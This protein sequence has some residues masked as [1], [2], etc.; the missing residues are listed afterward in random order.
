MGPLHIHVFAAAWVLDR[1]VAPGLKRAP[2]RMPESVSARVAL[3][4]EFCP[5]IEAGSSSL[6]VFRMLRQTR[7][8][9]M[10][11]DRLH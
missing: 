3:P 11:L 2:I 10:L 4:H 6:D 8:V 1:T 9:R 5:R 7:V